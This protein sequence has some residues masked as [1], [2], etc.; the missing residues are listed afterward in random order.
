MSKISFNDALNEMYND[1]KPKCKGIV[2]RASVSQWMSVQR[3]INF[4]KQLR[5]LKRKS[6]PGCE[7]CHWLWD[8]LSERMSEF[9]PQDSIIA[10]VEDGK[11]YTIITTNLSTD[12]ESG[13]I[14]G[15]DLEFIEYKEVEP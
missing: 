9:Y 7:Q 8:D 2:F 6:C 14:D 10:D 13:I 15:Y 3:D 11:L 5:V 1:T 4:K 12:W